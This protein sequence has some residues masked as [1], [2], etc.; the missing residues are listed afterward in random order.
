MTLIEAMRQAKHGDVVQR[1]YNVSGEDIGT[2]AFTMWGTIEV[3][4]RGKFLVQGWG[5]A[6]KLAALEA[7]N[8]EIVAKEE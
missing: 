3:T 4:P 2:M 5:K 6:L 1:K 7:D 8:W